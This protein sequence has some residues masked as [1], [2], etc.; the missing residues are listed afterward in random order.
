[1]TALAESTTLAELTT[2]RVGGP[3]AAYLVTT[4]EA[5]FIAAITQAD[6]DGTPLLVIGGGSNLV[7]ADAGFPGLVLRDGRSGWILDSADACSG[8]SVTVVAGQDWD[9]FVAAAVAERWVGLEALAGIPGTVGAAPVQNIGAYGAEVSDVL[10]KVRTWDRQERRVRTF[11]VGELA[12][13]YRTSLLKQTLGQAWSPTPRYVVL[14]VSFQLRRADVSR[15]LRYA[16][17]ARRLGRE[18]GQRAP[19]GEVREAVLGL[20]AAKG[21][22]AEHVVGGNTAAPEHD[23]WSAGSFFTNPVLPLER[24]ERLLPAAAPRYPVRAVIGA[25]MS[26]IYRTEVDPALVKTSAAWLIERAGFTKGYGLDGLAGGQSCS[27]ATLSTRHTLALTNRGGA[28]AA[29]IVSLARAICDGVQAKFGIELEPEPNL[30][31]LT[32]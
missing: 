20:R 17:L 9:G 12:L 31:G 29:D 21:M 16:E 26:G 23:R 7:V 14:D 22:L 13:G 4:T 18:V 2:L 32:I 6:D 1:M 24:A 30:V 11:A 3:A 25:G 28:T 27:P 19:L 8:A 5:E 10:S 15:P